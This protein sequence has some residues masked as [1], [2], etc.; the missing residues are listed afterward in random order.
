MLAIHLK[1]M[2]NMCKSIKMYSILII[3]GFD[4]KLYNVKLKCACINAAIVRALFLKT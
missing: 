4:L 1:S 3:L 2:K